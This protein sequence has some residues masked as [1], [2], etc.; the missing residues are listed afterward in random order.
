[1]TKNVTG[2]HAPRNR[3]V[4]LSAAEEV[5]L[6]DRVLRW[7]PTLP[8]ESLVNR[9]LQGD[10]LEVSQWL[11]DALFDLVIADPPYNLAKDFRSTS[12]R[13]LPGLNI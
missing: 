8:I 3:S 5:I 7:Q 1:M 13:R 4:R 11:P 10:S 12:F 6:H 9:T 2:N